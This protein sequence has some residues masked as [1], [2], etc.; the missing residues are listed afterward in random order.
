MIIEYISLFPEWFL[1]AVP[2]YC[3]LTALII[4]MIKESKNIQ[5][6]YK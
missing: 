1:L 4:I 5:R 2:G 3:I 6:I